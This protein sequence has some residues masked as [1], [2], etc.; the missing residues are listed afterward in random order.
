MRL[1]LEKQQNRPELRAILLFSVLFPC[2]SFMLKLVGQGNRWGMTRRSYPKG[3]AAVSL[4]LIV[5]ILDAVLKVVST[6]LK[7]LVQAWK[8]SRKDKKNHRE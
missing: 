5:K 3:G 7:T 4:D 2:T 1:T 6:G 8:Q